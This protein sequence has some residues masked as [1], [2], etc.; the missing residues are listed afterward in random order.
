[1]EDIVI[2]RLTQDWIMWYGWDSLKFVSNAFVYHYLKPEGI[3]V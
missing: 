1:L 2:A 3:G